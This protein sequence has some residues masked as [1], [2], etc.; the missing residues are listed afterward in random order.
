MMAR[1]TFRAILFLVAAALLHGCGQPLSNDWRIVPRYRIGTTLPS[2]EGDLRRTFGDRNVVE[3]R[4]SVGEGETKVGCILFPGDSLRRLEVTWQDS[5]QRA[6][7]ARVILRGNRSIWKLPRDLSLGMS[8]VELERKNGKRFTLSGFAWDYEGAVISW[9]GGDLDTALSSDTKVYLAPDPAGR[10][11]PEYARV[12][13]DRPFSSSLPEMRA[14]NPRVYQIFVD[15]EHLA[16]PG[17]SAYA[18]K[19]EIQE[20]DSGKT[21]AFEPNDRFTLILDDRTHPQRTLASTPKGIVGRVS[22]VPDVKPPLYA[23]R[24]EAVE[25]GAATISAKGFRV[26]VI[27]REQ[28]KPLSS[29]P[30]SSDTSAASR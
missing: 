26:S 11:R 16:D 15:F 6:I 23:A 5:V 21:F 13:G 8:L 18:P 7:P 4:I 28:A 17:E 14:L 19:L 2:N 9:E 27:V 22:N 24:F 10:S 20:S 29:S 3:A 1:R 12:Q 25:R 30:S